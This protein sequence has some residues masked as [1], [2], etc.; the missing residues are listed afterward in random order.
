MRG[1]V[2]GVLVLAMFGVC[3]AA[4]APAVVQKP[5]DWTL[6]VRF[7]NP[8]QITLDGCCPA[9]LLVHNSYPDQ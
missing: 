8:Q 5:G 6:D 4:P 7:E 3:W 9:A 2:I 1:L